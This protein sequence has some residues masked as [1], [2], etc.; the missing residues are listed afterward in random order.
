MAAD[1]V[2]G[3]VKA[4]ATVDGYCSV[5]KYNYRAAGFFIDAE[6]ANFFKNFMRVTK[7]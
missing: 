3:K 7:E 4:T 2:D 1:Q 5:L 6:L